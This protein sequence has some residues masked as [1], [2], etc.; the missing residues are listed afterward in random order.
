MQNKN[1]GF[2]IAVLCF[3]LGACSGYRG[4]ER[5]PSAAAA[6]SPARPAAV[7][8]TA[9]TAERLLPSYDD[10]PV[11]PAWTRYRDALDLPDPDHQTLEADST[12]PLP[13]LPH[14]HIEAKHPGSPDLWDRLRAGYALPSYDNPRVRAELGWY[15]DHPDYLARSIER[16]RPYLHFIVAELEQRGMP[17][18][19]ALLPIVESAYQ[20][21]AYSHGRAAGL[22]QFIPS[23]ASLYGLRQS[24]WYD[25]RR[26]V[27]AS[28]HAALDYL[29]YLSRY[30]DGDWLLA[31][32]AY[33]S[34]EGAV[35]RAI[36]RNEAA[37]KPTDFW[38]L[39]LSRETRAY[40]PKLLALKELFADPENYSIALES[41][42]D[43][44]VVT[45][46][47]V[48]SQIDIA[49]AAQLAD[50]SIEEFYRL[51]PAF[52]RWATDPDGP[53]DLLL[54]VDR[55][56][57]FY[58]KLSALDPA[59]RVTWS[60]HTVRRGETLGQIAR[61][62]GIEAGILQKVNNLSSHA[63]R[64]GSTLVIP[65]G[66]KGEAAVLPVS[67]KSA[68][69]QSPVKMEHVVRNGDTLWGISRDHGVGLDK[70]AEWNSLASD[71]VLRPGQ[72]LVI[73]KTERAAANDDSLPSS[74]LPVRDMLRRINYVVRKGDSLTRI[75]QRFRVSV[76]DVRKWNSLSHKQRLRPGQS[77]T[78]YVD[79]TRQTANL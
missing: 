50:L 17:L 53:H 58:E 20:P 38:S 8:E 15:A 69:P 61:H 51:N 33:N 49:K 4:L 6:E 37:G 1:N 3:A 9:G 24:W 76:A 57:D 75:S 41:I 29:D 43:E 11:A 7:A 77:L 5:A 65:S 18:E 22:W 45:Q 71:D 79:V 40:V 74:G 25:G 55:V 35:K 64:A 39:N 59:S 31:L 34:G 46:V 67:A 73:W 62:Y 66:P 44:A 56:D 28:T 26:D 30:F 2:L 19:I 72:R 78:L 47:N 52:N 14:G 36:E 23:T 63:L 60:R 68:A 10:E 13:I 54:P 12:R 21:F 27:V 32:A 42:P 16:A 48:G 70:L